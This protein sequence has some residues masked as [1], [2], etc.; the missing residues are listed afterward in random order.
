MNLWVTAVKKIISLHTRPNRNDLY[1]HKGYVLPRFVPFLAL[2]KKISNA[3]S[4]NI[5]QTFSLIKF[6][7]YCIFDWANTHNDI[8]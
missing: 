8:Q 3:K 7:Q 6:W 4:N 2:E 5:R 1:V